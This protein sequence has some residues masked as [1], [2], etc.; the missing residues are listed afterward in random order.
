MARV[1]SPSVLVC[2]SARRSDGPDLSASASG[3][4]IETSSGLWAVTSAAWMSGSELIRVKPRPPRC[5]PSPS[6]SVAWEA[7]S[8]SGQ[9]RATVLFQFVQDGNETKTLSVPAKIE[10]VHLMHSVMESLQR[11][12]S[13]L[14]HWHC[15]TGQ[16]GVAEEEEME[17]KAKEDGVEG[18]RRGSLIGRRGGGGRGGGGRG[19]VGGRGG[20]GGGGVGERGRGGGGAGGRSGVGGERGGGLLAKEGSHLNLLLLPLSCV[21]VLR[22]SKG[23]ESLW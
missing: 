22:L 9:F 4:V 23:K 21:V 16:A 5:T 10:G 15:S 14:A 11:E 17:A 20:R 19:G 2:A 3:F 8:G 6:C 7:G 12:L 1:V 18:G 13:S